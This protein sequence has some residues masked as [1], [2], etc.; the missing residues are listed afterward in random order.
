MILIKILKTSDIELNMY[1]V[2]VCIDKIVFKLK[3]LCRE[4]RSDLMSHHNTQLDHRWEQVFIGQFCLQ[5]NCFLGLFVRLG[6]EA[7]IRTSKDKS[8]S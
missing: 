6:H 8:R 3:K 5:N 4:T 2:F 7:V 1:F